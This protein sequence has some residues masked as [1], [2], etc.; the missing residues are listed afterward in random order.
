MTHRNDLAA[1]VSFTDQDL[2]VVLVDGRTLTVPLTWYPRLLN[3]SKA[4]RDDWQILGDGEIIHWPRIDEDLS[5]AGL[6]MGA[7]APGHRAGAR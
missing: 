3:A 2:K 1:S 6:L 4:E 7:P 5:T